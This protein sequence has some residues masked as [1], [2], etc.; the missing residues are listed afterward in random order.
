MF[1]RM[2]AK[3]LKPDLGKTIAICEILGNPE[4]KFRSVHIAGTN[5][6]GSV[7]H[8]MAAVLQQ[9]G[10][11]TGLFTSPH[12]RDFRER[13]R[14]NGEMV[15]KDFVTDFV[16][17]SMAFTTEI[18]P[19]FFE[20]TFGMAMDYFAEEQ[21]DVAVIET[22]LGGRL[23]STNVIVPK[24]SIITNIGYDHMDV[25]GDTLEK[26]AQEKAGI[27]KEKVP[28]IIGET[29]RE[30]RSV[31]INT[32][33][34]RHAGIYF[35][36]KLFKVTAA[37]VSNGFMNLVIEEVSTGHADSWQLDLT[38][39]YQKKNVLSV[40]QAVR[41]L[42]REFRLDNDKVRQALSEVVQLTNFEGRWQIIHQRPL[43][44]MDVGHN[45]DGIRQLTA[46]LTSMKYNRLHIV[47]GMVKDKDV[48]AVLELLPRDAD[49][50]FTNAHIARALPA[51][52][53]LLHAAERGLAGVAVDDVNEAI[54][55][56]CHHCYKDDLI[57]VCGSV[58][59]VGEADTQRILKSLEG[60]EIPDN[61][62]IF[63]QQL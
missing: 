15:P 7:S 6:K 11:K 16:A 59:V 30:T 12:L 49:Y 20:L 50:Y 2:G 24:L 32:A 5:G 28:V 38:A 21:V 54:L 60:I 19:S 31:F 58:F 48:S 18:K 47:T 3:A 37:E 57:L 45:S 25:L 63:H 23:D 40:L 42:Q 14:I 26:I 55:A 43:I 62:D 17:R 46:Q 29:H 53:L 4:R 13:I 36:D 51:R 39:G 27:I 35:A 10:F 44:I 8:M 22:G 33:A 61:P 52:E 34:Q 9:H 41:L 1:S 56:A